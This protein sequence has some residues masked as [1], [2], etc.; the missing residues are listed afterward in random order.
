MQFIPFISVGEFLYQNTIEEIKRLVKENFITGV[1]EELDKKYLSL[2]IPA[3]GIFIVFSETSDYIRTIE[4]ENDVFIQEV[5]I[6]RM[7]FEN[8]KCFIEENDKDYKMI[9]D[10]T[11]ESKKDGFLITKKTDNSNVLTFYSKKYL[12]EDDILPDEII[13]YYLG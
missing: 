10:C 2:Y 12:Q 8:I 6:F 11:L 5:N 9:D 13:K 4:V 7:S 3:R 1:K